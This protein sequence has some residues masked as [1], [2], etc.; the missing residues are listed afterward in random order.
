M[1]FQ[2]RNQRPSQL[3]TLHSSQLLLVTANLPLTMDDSRLAHTTVDTMTAVQA[4]V[5]TTIPIIAIIVTIAMLDETKKCWRYA[6]CLRW[7]ILTAFQYYSEVAARM[8]ISFRSRTSSFV[9]HR[10][11]HTA[12]FTVSD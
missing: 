7:I 8:C 1:T 5:A 4:A 2:H 3:S 11:I 9:H 10:H 6:N 12:V